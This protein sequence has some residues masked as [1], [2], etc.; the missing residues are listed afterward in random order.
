MFASVP[1]SAG[2]EAIPQEARRWAGM[3][4]PCRPLSSS[5]STGGV[6]GMTQSSCVIL[7][8]RAEQLSSSGRGGQAQPDSLHRRIQT[9]RAVS[10]QH[11]RPTAGFSEMLHE[12]W[13][14]DSF[15]VVN[16]SGTSNQFSQRV[17]GCLVCVCDSVSLPLTELKVRKM[18]ASCVSLG[19]VTSCH[20]QS[21]L[22]PT[23]MRKSVL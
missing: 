5:L 13:D 7:C 18:M 19:G 15:S 22:Y 1:S 12:A 8:D 14:P 4:P 20:P 16:G 10:M 3:A 17:C 21:E 11:A 23:Q 6:R 2:A 9:K